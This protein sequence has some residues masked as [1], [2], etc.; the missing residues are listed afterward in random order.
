[1][2]PLFSPSSRICYSQQQSRYKYIKSVL[3]YHFFHS[4]H[5]FSHTTL[6]IDI[7][8]YYYVLYACCLCT[9]CSLTGSVFDPHWL[10]VIAMLRMM[11]YLVVQ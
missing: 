5:S 9:T 10:N 3:T 1:M 8:L 6:Q 4:L 2:K 11:A 7:Q